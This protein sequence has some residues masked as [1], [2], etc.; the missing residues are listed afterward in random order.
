MR[1]LFLRLTDPWFPRG[2][3]ERMH[4]RAE[5]LRDDENQTMIGR[6]RA[7]CIVGSHVL[8]TAWAASRRHHLLV[9][10]LL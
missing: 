5:R 1:H 8:P 6:L 7:V 4:R 2:A 10:V 3:I 9:L